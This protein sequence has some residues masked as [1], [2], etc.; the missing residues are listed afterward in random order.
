MGFKTPEQTS[1]IVA[2][3]SAKKCYS[4]T[5][6]L[7]ILSF[8]AGAYMAL[9]GM[10]GEIVSSGLYNTG[11]PAGLTNMAFS[12][13]FPVG[14]ILIVLTGSNLFT[15]NIFM[16]TFGYM[17]NRFKIKDLL[18]DWTG[19]YLINLIGALFVAFVL[20]YY[21]GIMTVEPF[22]STAIMIAYAKAYG[23]ADLYF[24]GHI[25]HTLTFIQ[26]FIKGIGCNWLISLGIFMAT[27][28]NDLTSKAVS[29]WLTLFS[30]CALGFEHAVAN[31]YL[32]P[33][34]MLLGAHINF[35][36]FITN[37]LIPVT[38]GNVVGGAI[39]VG[40]AYGFLYLKKGI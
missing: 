23:G 39:F 40:C 15:G 10:I 25:L 14:L 6:K 24:H 7:I 34:G 3:I 27:S 8:L 31:M 17:D 9:G 2:D 21:S 12:T 26:A 32:I 22:K 4:S 37:N 30:F 36:Q 20:A 33:I 28:A 1:Q 18:I 35:L 38:L 19:T 16:L 11:M 29:I 5:G 13:V